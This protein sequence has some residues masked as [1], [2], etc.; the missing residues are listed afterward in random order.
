LQQFCTLHL[1]IFSW[2][3]LSRLIDRQPF[4]SL[5]LV[6][7][8]TLNPARQA[9]YRDPFCSIY[10]YEFNWRRAN[11]LLTSLEANDKT[12]GQLVQGIYPVTQYLKALINDDKERNE[13]VRC[14]M[15]WFEQ[16]LKACPHLRQ[17]ELSFKTVNDFENLLEALSLGLSWPKDGVLAGPSSLRTV[18][19]S[20]LFYDDEEDGEIDAD[21]HEHPEL[22]ISDRF[23]TADIFN[24]LGRTSITSLDEVEYHNVGFVH[25]GYPAN[26]PQ[27]PF[28]V[29]S[30]R[31]HSHSYTLATSIPLLPR[32]HSA[33]EHFG[34]SGEPPLDS[35][36]IQA[37]PNLL[38]TTLRSLFLRL[39]RADQF[40]LSEYTLRS[41]APPLPLETFR[42]FPHLTSLS[43][44]GTHGP[45]PRFLELLAT[46]S[47]L[48]THLSF[49]CSRW[50][51]DTDP[52]SFRPEV[53][54]P[55]V[56]ILS[57]LSKFKHLKDIYL[58]TLPTT[59]HNKYKGLKSSLEAEGIKGEGEY[60]CCIRRNG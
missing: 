4:L 6:S 11:S 35:S 37:L 7:R 15:R 16:L 56:Q 5:C 52:Q 54:F 28:P 34:F 12:L 23:N 40:Y 46:A 32:N 18:V 43:L 19:F 53:I 27:F 58:G 38:G 13:T 29:K 49:L 21:G 55:E 50:V 47:P 10:P 41:D 3:T 8:Q 39:S 31:I 24:A 30:L 1:T 2:L 44:V 42:L 20:R 45:S 17:V 51:S 57:S 36:E 59:K 14:T 48:I 25:S 22:S 9:L 60:E 26:E 33:L